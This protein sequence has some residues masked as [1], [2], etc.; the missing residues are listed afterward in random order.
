M[1]IHKI[2]VAGLALLAWSTSVYA[3]N[4]VDALRYSYLGFGGTARIQGL[5]GAQTALGADASTMAA[6]P[7]GLGLYRKGEFTFT[8]GFNFNETKSTL[9]GN[10]VQGDRN[11]FNISQMGLVFTDRKPDDVVSKWRSGSFGI[12]FTRLNNFQVTSN[13]QSGVS[14]ERSFLQSLQDQIDKG[15]VTVGSLNQEVSDFGGFTSIPGLAYDAFLIDADTIPNTQELGLFVP[16]FRQG[17]ITQQE[18][19]RSEGAQNQWD[20][21]YGGSFMDKLFIGG[22]L[23]VISTRYKQTRS[24]TEESPEDPSLTSYTL[25]DQFITK[26]SGVNIRI[27]AIYKP[28]DAL[29]LGASIQTPTWASLSDDYIKTLTVNYQPGTFTGNQTQFTSN[30]V[31][32][33]YDYNLTTPFRANGGIAYFIGKYGFISADVEYLDYSD[34]SFNQDND[35][36]IFSAVNN[37]ISNTYQSVVNYRVGAEARF[38]IF[39][40]RGGFALYGDPYQNS[41]YDRDRTYYTVGIGIKESR[42][43][44]DAAYVQSKYNSI[45]S[46]YSLTD[47]TQPVVTTGVKN[48]SFLITGGFNF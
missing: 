15:S 47:H 17:P 24:F 19:T 28:I 48:V 26:G 31:P 22:S 34:A 12:G 14:E 2:W 7:A 46:P 32:G 27:G 16:W 41:S 6:N 9:N 38:D 40:V 21:S 5:A 23:S 8:P 43:F 29:R 42:Y 37:R 25:T 10:T 36:T 20:F 18:I 11:T 3:Q 4:E 30:A 45:Y 33:V 39:R 13:Y 1:N 35:L 44:I